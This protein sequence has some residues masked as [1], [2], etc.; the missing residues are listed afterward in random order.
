MEKM[1]GIVDIFGDFRK[2]EREKWI[3]YFQERF[4]KV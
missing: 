4:L 2:K 3:K 1:K